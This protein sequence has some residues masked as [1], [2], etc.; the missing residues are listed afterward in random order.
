MTPPERDPNTF[1]LALAAIGVLGLTLYGIA[2]GRPEPIQQAVQAAAIVV[3]VVA[4]FA[5]F[6]AFMRKNGTPITT[7]TTYPCGATETQAGFAYD[8]LAWYPG[9]ASKG[10]PSHR[11]KCSSTQRPPHPE[12]G[13]PQVQRGGGDE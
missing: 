10:C 9:P 13:N 12:V 6:R 8:G 2:A 5:L 11:N 7:T 3:A 4:G 1:P